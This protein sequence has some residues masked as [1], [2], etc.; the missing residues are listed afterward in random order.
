MIPQMR[1]V[2]PSNA[3]KRRA[4]QAPARYPGR[5]VGIL[6]LLACL[7]AAPALAQESLKLGDLITGRLRFFLHQHPNGTWIK[8]Y[9]IVADHPRKFAEPDEFCDSENPPK[10]FHFMVMDDPARKRRL[11]RMRGKTVSV[12]ADMFFC[13]ETAWH[14]GDAVLGKW[15]FPEDRRR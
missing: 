8:V 15:H 4:Q 9:Q 6:A 5:W 10:T 12:V 13:S 2:T 1:L 11:D 3:P 14:V 7:V